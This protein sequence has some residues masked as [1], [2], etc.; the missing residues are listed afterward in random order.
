[1]A[2]RSNDGFTVVLPPFLG[3]TGPGVWRPTPPA[4]L[5]GA[6]PQ[7]ATAT[8][9]VL[10]SPSQFR[11]EPFPA[12]TSA[13]YA[14]DFNEVK[15]LGSATSAVRS[16]DQTT[17]AFFWASASTPVYTWDTVATSLMAREDGREDRESDDRSNRANPNLGHALVEH[18]RILALVNIAI[19]DG[20]IAAWD[21][22][23]H[24]LLWRPITAIALADT[25]GNPA[26]SPDPTWTP[27]IITPP[28]PTYPSGLLTVSSAAVTMLASVFGER[29]RFTVRSDVLLGV[30]RS[31]RSF[32]ASLD[33]ITDARVLSGIH[34]RFDDVAGRM[35]GT[36]VAN[37]ILEHALQPLKGQP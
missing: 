19:S 23:Y 3:G 20:V 18:A 9:W 33:E 6:T 7:L 8:P 2:F 16:V 14:A 21:G 31:F 22:K 25:D 35:T 15:L 28:Y 5:P 29:T 24:Y 36:A 26:T 10:T 32:S 27:L 4:F 34:F 11:P 30:T 17:L 12:L 37:Y 1:V 13:E